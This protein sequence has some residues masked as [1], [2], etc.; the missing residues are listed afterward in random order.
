MAPDMS[1]FQGLGQ[2][3]AVLPTFEDV[4][5][6]LQS[7]NLYAVWAACFGVLLLCGFG[8]PIP[9]DITLVLCGYMTYEL[10]HDGSYGNPTVL[11]SLAIAIGLAG[12]L[13]GD[14][15]M[16]T[17]GQRYGK[18]LMV[19]W[20]FA[21]IMGSGRKELAEGFLREKGPQ[22]L[23]SARFMPGLR[24]VVF[25]TSGTLGIGLPTFLLFDGL[26]ALLSVPALIGS[27]WYFGEN[28]DAVIANARQAEHGI[29]VIILLGGGGAALK[30][31]LGQ[32]KKAKAA[33][34]K[35]PPAM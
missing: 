4:T 12:V 8:L 14:G 9:E 7:M 20:P 13:I 1:L 27:S 21:S 3:L 11:V 16:F 15:I 34:D 33:S 18:Y 6:I 31:W 26:A 28:I 22:V 19:R 2:S 32:R 5:G 24:S 30:Y 17:L 10:G 25:F 23:F 29:L 35:L